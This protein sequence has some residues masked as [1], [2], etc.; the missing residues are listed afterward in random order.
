M[1]WLVTPDQND[2]TGFTV[3]ELIIFPGK[4]HERHNHEGSDELLFFL[5][6][7]GV[8]MVDDGDPFPVKTGDAIF[9]KD[10]MYHST[11]NAGWSP[12]RILAVYCPGGQEKGFK[13]L[14]DFRGLPAGAVQ[15]LIRMVK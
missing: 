3:G 4:G 7:E 11:M 14:P 8:Q 9:L 5:S 10:G 12:L 2:N 15:E 6:G 13:D 1:K